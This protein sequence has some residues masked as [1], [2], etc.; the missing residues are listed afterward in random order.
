MSNYKTIENQK[1]ILSSVD[2]KR[3]NRGGFI[4]NEVEVCKLDFNCENLEQKKTVI[5]KILSWLD[6][7]LQSN[8]IN[9]IIK[10]LTE[11]E[12]TVF[13]QVKKGLK[14]DLLKTFSLKIE[15]TIS[16]QFQLI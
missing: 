15:K 10:D 1:L 13:K 8:V 14:T 4:N 2:F 6:C 12:Y 11:R 5:K 9:K 7:D 3:S 16:K